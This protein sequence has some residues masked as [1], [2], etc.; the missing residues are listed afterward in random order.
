MSDTMDD[1]PILDTLSIPLESFLSDDPEVLLELI[2]DPL[3]PS[4][5]GLNNDSRPLGL[6]IAE[7]RLKSDP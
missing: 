6:R 7:I 2:C 1:N 5:L 3:V 4:D